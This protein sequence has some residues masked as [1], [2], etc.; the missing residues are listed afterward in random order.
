MTPLLE[1]KG[2]KKHF[3]ITKGFLRRHVG[4]VKALDGID[5]I[6]GEGEVVG[7]VGES[8][9]GKS[10]AGRTAIRL[11]DP[12][13]GSVIFDGKDITTMTRKDLMP[14]RK[15]MQMI[16]QDPYASLN[17]RKTVAETLI[18]P[19][20]YHNIVSN[21]KEAHD[22][23]VE[24]LEQVGLTTDALRRYPH[25]FSGGQQQ[26]ICVGRALVVNPRL[27]IC[28]EAVSALDV[29]IQAQ[30]LNLLYELRE[31]HNLSY[32][33]ISHDL[34][35]VRHLCDRVVVLYLGKVMESAPTEELFSNPKHPYTKTLMSAIPKDHPDEK[36]E[37]IVCSGEIPSPRNP[38]QG[39]PFN[40][41]CPQ[42]QDRCFKRFP[43]KKTAE[44]SPEHEYYCVLD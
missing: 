44:G 10:T 16:F 11:L 15:E 30:I 13:E 43:E 18:E 22:V 29:S 31:K 4:N 19:L 2:L 34:S 41:R 17:P 6:V 26:R 39:C 20:E 5:L 42:A 9:C 37:R 23:I 3:P 33:F 27:I 21:R 36:K 14:L 7:L 40:T 24:I 28:D 25:E 32:L 12:T 35:V 38:P 1:I 8:G